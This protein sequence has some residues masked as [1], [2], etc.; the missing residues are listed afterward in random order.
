VVDPGG[1]GGRRRLLPRPK[2]CSSNPARFSAG[3]RARR[4]PTARS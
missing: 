2:G 3:P 1:R 4:G